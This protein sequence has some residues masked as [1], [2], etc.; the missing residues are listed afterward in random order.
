MQ[1]SACLSYI[2]SLVVVCALPNTIESIAPD[3][4]ELQKYAHLSATAYCLKHGL[5][6]GS[7]EEQGAACPSKS[8][9]YSSIG[10]LEVVKTFD[11]SQWFEV[12][13]GFIALEPETETIYLVF[14]GTSSNQD[15]AN[16][17]S[18]FPVKYKPLVTSKKGFEVESGEICDGC[19]IHKGFDVFI[20]ANGEIVVKEVVKLKKKYPTYR[21][22]VVGHLLGGALATITGVEFRLL[23]FDTLVVT[24]AAPKVGNGNFRDFMDDLFMTSDVEKHIE[25]NR[26]FDTLSIGHIRIVHKHDI[27]PMLPPTEAYKHAGFEYYL[28]KTGTLQLP[29]TVV[30]RGVD[31]I[32][33][34]EDLDWR[35]MLPSAL[36]RSDHVGYFITITKCRLED[37]TS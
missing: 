9:R 2:I 30:R 32:E 18:A 24:L 33:E 6:G 7:L 14:R 22:V 23:G 12:G 17:L 3:Y 27:I 35:S 19:T 31:Y 21:V 13:S 4:F 10:H 11:F 16:N 37:L 8:C 34:L 26:S 36:S 5:H 29:S 1:L 20:K 15:W 28:S 25:Y